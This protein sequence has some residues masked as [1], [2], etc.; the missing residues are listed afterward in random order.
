MPGSIVPISRD[1]KSASD[2]LWIIEIFQPKICIFIALLHVFSPLLLSAQQQHRLI[3]SV[4][5]QRD[6]IRI[7]NVAITLVGAAGNAISTGITDKEGFCALDATGAT[8][9]Y[10]KIAGYSNYNADLPPSRVDTL[11]CWISKNTVSLKSVEI[12]EKQVISDVGKLVYKVR[13]DQFSRGQSSTELLRK[14]PG[15]IVVG[16]QIKLHG[17]TGVLIL[18]DGKGEHRT[19]RQQQAILASL[20][21]DQLDKVEIMTMPSARYDAGINAVINIITKKERGNSNIRATYSQ[22]FYMTANNA[23][24][25]YHSGAGAAN[26]NLKIRRVS[27]TWIMSTENTLNTTQS[28][29]WFATDKGFRYNDL[30]KSDVAAFRIT[31]DLNLDYTINSRSSVGLNVNMRQAPSSISNTTERYIFPKDSV[32]EINNMNTRK[33]HTFQ[34]TINYKY[35]LDTAKKSTL[36]FSGTWSASPDDSRNVL[37]RQTDAS[38]RSLMQN[39]INSHTDIFSA[40]VIF[41][42]VIKTKHLSTEFGIKSNQLRNNTNQQYDS[43]VLSDFHYNEQINSAFFSARWKFGKWRMATELRGEQLQSKAQYQETAATDEYIRRD[44]WKLYPNLLLQYDVNKELEVSVGYTKR[45]RRPFMGD[46]NPT[47]RTTNAL[48]T[49]EGSIDFMPS[50]VNRVEGQLLYKQSA[51]TLRYESLNNRRV[52]VPTDDPFEY[53]AINMTRFESFGIS[54]NQSVQ[55]LK[56]FTSNIT[57]D[58]FYSR[59]LQPGSFNTSTNLFEVSMDNEWT[60]DKKTRLLI[61]AYYN[62]RMY[63]EYSMYNQLLSTSCT[64]KRILLKNKLFLQLSVSDPFGVEKVRSRSIYPNQSMS[65]DAVTNNR[66]FSLQLLYSFPFGHKVKLQSYRTKNEGEIRGY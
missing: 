33:Q 46:M 6:S 3:V 7:T 59:Y 23:G 15:V 52:F 58:Y 4:M 50:F 20:T 12:F 44:Y 16:E 35:I 49:Q 47:R 13:Q 10:C 51:V 21:A 48:M 63:L 57:V 42:D 14:L 32:T 60:I 5:D 2:N 11:I 31:Q 37:Y 8:R 41:T 43:S 17:Q 29:G 34:S 22:P 62:A 28:A 30:R 18:I 61:S 36:C 45:V 24:F 9:I 55:I 64:V 19:T 54:M 1:L 53:K 65:V 40:T 38:S 66:R 56:N 26:L 27:C 25:G 39:I